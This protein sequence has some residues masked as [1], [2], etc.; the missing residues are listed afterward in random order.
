MMPDRM[1]TKR[2]RLYG[3][4]QGVGFRPFVS[5][6]A[7]DQGILGSVCNRGSYVE[8]IARGS[9]ER[10]LRFIDILRSDPPERSVIL[11]IDISDARDMPDM[12]SFQ[13]IESEKEKGE[14]LTRIESLEMSVAKI[15]KLLDKLIKGVWFI[16]VILVKK[17]TPL[18]FGHLQT[19]IGVSGNSEV[20]RKLHHPDPRVLFR[21]F[22]TQCAAAVRRAVVHQQH[23]NI[24]VSLLQN[25]LH[26]PVQIAFHIVN[27]YDNAD[28]F[29]I[30]QVSPIVK[31]PLRFVPSGKSAWQTL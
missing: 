11:K 14:I 3:I 6:A 2:I 15:T 21:P 20:F 17:R 16:Q 26:A 10:V 4:V 18:S 19:G 7:M 27:G 5:R 12:D 13:I 30:H 9:E 24:W 28:R 1:Q 8:V 23:F 29:I 25:A 31:H 22:V